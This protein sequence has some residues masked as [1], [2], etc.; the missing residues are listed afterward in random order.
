[1]SEKSLVHLFP[2]LARY[3]YEGVPDDALVGRYVH[4]R[5]EGA[6]T[7]LVQRHGAMVLAVCRRVLRNSADADDV[8]QATFMVLARKADAIRPAGAVGPW[9]HGVAFRTAREALRRA[10]R[11]RAKESRVVP[12]EPIPEPVAPDVR[13]VLDAEL[14]RLPKAFARVLVLCDMEGRTRRDVA[15]LLD[16]PEGTV[17]SRLARAREMLAA[18]LTRRGVGLSVGALATVLS[19]DPGAAV[20]PELLAGTVRSALTF[21]AGRTVEAVSPSVLELTNTVLRAHST[22]LKFLIVGL[23]VA[24][25]GVGGWA[26]MSETRPRQPDP[27]RTSSAISDVAKQPQPVPV[28]NPAAALRT[29]LAG[30]WKVDAGVRDG[31]PLTDWEKNGFRFDFNLSGALTIYR[32]LIQDQRAFTWTI[33]PN[34]APPTIV[35]TPPNA[36]A[37]GAVRVAF[38]LREGSL[39]LSWD[40]PQTGRGNPRAA[41]GV[42]SRLTLSKVASASSSTELVVAPAAQNVVGTRLAGSWEADGALNGRLGLAAEPDPDEPPSKTTLTFTSD[43]T[44]ARDVPA[45]YRELFAEKRVYLSGVMAV[46]RGSRKPVSY[47]FLLIEHAG[48]ALLVYFVPHLRDE[49]NCEE[50]A[51]VMLVPGTERE[52]DLL[53]LSAFENAPHAPVGGFRRVEVKK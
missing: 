34:A 28:L 43:S 8:F 36:N 51:T 41:R 24:V 21:G 45:A 7:E 29:Q 4:E 26:A 20:P 48:N 49:W 37:V 44:V 12:R 27:E 32:G 15:A 2:D 39:T 23:V 19:A 47:R 13:H 46:A 5:D 25:A 14:D 50:A 30:V 11:R 22:R 16:L 42:S 17:A 6:F 31:R 10:A 53:F 38:E 3:R 18:R 33:E 1:M 40:D 35:L 9:L 52:K